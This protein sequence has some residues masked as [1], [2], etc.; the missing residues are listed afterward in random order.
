MPFLNTEVEPSRICLGTAVYGSGVS[1]EQSF[2]LLDAF[3][4]C[5]GTFVDTAH[6]YA[7]WLPHGRGASERTVGEWIRANG[8]RDR[9]VLATKGGHPPLNNMELGAC[10]REG[11]VSN[12]DESLERLGLDSVDLYWLHRDDPARGVGEIVD[13]LADFVQQGRIGAFGGS[14]WTWPRLMDANAYARATGVPGMVASQ[15]GWALVDRAPG[16]V[17]VVNMYYLDEETRQ[18]HVAAGFPLVAYTAQARGFFGEANVRWAK[19]GFHGIAP[20]A[21]EYDTETGRGR[22][23]RAIELGEKKGHS[24]NQIA[25]AYIL[26]QPFPAYAI[27]GTS[28]VETVREA[29]AAETIALTE[30]E[31]D[32][33]RKGT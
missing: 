21:P 18:E 28:K 4:E 26:N 17:P 7:D 33:L 22:L 13:T 20:L 2:A 32:Y 6:V 12:L 1:R 24:A 14:N 10:S 9:V 15:P 16:P 5:G 30:R 29:C 8:M 23:S 25:L 27:I 3:A 11:L 19:G 31:C